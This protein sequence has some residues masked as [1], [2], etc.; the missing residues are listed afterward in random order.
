MKLTSAGQ[1]AMLRT[2]E[3][4][5]VSHLGDVYSSQRISAVLPRLRPITLADRR[6]TLHDGDRSNL[7]DIHRAQDLIDDIGHYTSDRNRLLCDYVQ[8]QRDVNDH[9]LCRPKK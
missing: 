2:Y 4:T 6:S 7:D 5:L 1:E 8:W 9:L 3:D